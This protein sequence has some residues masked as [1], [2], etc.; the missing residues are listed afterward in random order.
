MRLFRYLLKFPKFCSSD[1]ISIVYVVIHK[2]SEFAYVKEYIENIRK[3]IKQ[4]GPKCG[5]FLII[6][7]FWVEALKV[8]ILILVKYM[9]QKNGNESDPVSEFL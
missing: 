6:I 7:F 2:D 5:V 4:K 8:Q 3:W 1:P 9:Q